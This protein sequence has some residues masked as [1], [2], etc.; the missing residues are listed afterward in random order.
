M[1]AYRY[2]RDEKRLYVLQKYPLYVRDGVLAYF[3]GHVKTHYIIFIS[4]VFAQNN[5]KFGK[6]QY[7]ITRILASHG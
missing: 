6:M 1:M 5:N 4:Y 3:R 2:F 7:Q